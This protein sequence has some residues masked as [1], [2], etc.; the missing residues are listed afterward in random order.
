MQTLAVGPP[1][2]KNIQLWQ[3]RNVQNKCT[4]DMYKMVIYKTVNVCIWSMH[5]PYVYNI[6]LIRRRKEKRPFLTVKLKS[7][8]KKLR[9]KLY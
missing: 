8:I 7:L 1:K 5:D 6:I 9:G 4:I 3:I 2:T